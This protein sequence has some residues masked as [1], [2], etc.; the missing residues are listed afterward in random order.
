MFLDSLY[1]ALFHFC[2]AAMLFT[3]LFEIYIITQNLIISLNFFANTV[4]KGKYFSKLPN[5]WY[6]MKTEENNV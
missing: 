4:R 1:F 3:A 2:C 5:I 6:L